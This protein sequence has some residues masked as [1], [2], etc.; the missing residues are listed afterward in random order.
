MKQD[1]DRGFG[2]DF[3]QYGTTCQMWYLRHR[4]FKHVLS[5][6]DVSRSFRSLSK[7]LKQNFFRICRNK[8]DGANVRHSWQVK[9]NVVTLAPRCRDA[10]NW[11]MVEYGRIITAQMLWNKQLLRDVCFDSKNQTTGREFNLSKR[12]Y[13]CTQPLSIQGMFSKSIFIWIFPNN[14]SKRCRWFGKWRHDSCDSWS[15][16]KRWQRHGKLSWRPSKKVQGWRKRKNLRHV[17]SKHWSFSKVGEVCEVGR[18]D[19]M[20]WVVFCRDKWFRTLGFDDHLMARTKG[21]VDQRGANEVGTLEHSGAA[22]SASGAGPARTWDSWQG[23]GLLG[24][25]FWSALKVW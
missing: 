16:H 22:T 17:C 10:Q 8:R 7:F 1:W 9:R 19:F 13:I 6:A 23:P 3:P 15:C 21:K 20:L 14:L 18:V 25:Q 11:L 4:C 24:F 5:G 12:F 2:G